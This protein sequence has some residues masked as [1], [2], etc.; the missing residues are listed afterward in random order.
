MRLEHLELLRSPET[1]GR[2]TLEPH[3][4]DADN[5]VRGVLRDEAGHEYP[6]VAGI[7]RFVPVSNY[8]D[9]FTVEWA[10]WPDI[11]SSYSGYGERFEK[12]TRWG[13]HLAGEVILEAGCGSGAFSP[14]ALATGATVVSL[15][16]S[17]GVEAAAARTAGH[18]KH[19]V[20]QADIFKM[21]VA[22]Q[23][24]DRAFC[25]GVIQHTPNPKKALGSVI[26][27][28][29]PGG[30]LAADIYIRPPEWAALET[31]K[32]YWRNVIKTRDPD[33]L[34]RRIVAYVRWVYPLARWIEPFGWGKK[35]NRKI[36][37]DDY[38]VR[39]PGMDP[40]KY[41]QFAALDIFDFLSPQYDI[42]ASEEEFRSWFSE[43]G[44][45]EVDVHLGF[46][47]IEGRGRRPL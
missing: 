2:L 15:D 30:S 14:H 45:E 23:S 9:S 20:V 7:P 11:L 5:I 12:E 16:Y 22:P 37:F 42:P 29:K 47:G 33:V 6:I 8:C 4:T 19:L 24:F 46:N 18:P 41:P 28:V 40:K 1:G 31:A 13:K 21:P 17:T 43:F 10:K 3:D 35:I 34:Y 27:A 44:L 39:L 32:Y 36:L 26:G 38:K 25:F